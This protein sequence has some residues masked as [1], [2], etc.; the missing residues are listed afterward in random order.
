MTHPLM[1][2]GIG[3]TLIGLR[4]AP[5]TLVPRGTG[6]GIFADPIITLTTIQARIAGTFVHVGQTSIIIVS[7]RTVAVETIN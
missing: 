1:L 4:L 3:R 2:T 6:T 5:D 7:I